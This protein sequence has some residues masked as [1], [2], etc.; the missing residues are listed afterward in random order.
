MPQ[1]RSGSNERGRVERLL[2]ELQKTSY[3]PFPEPR[4]RLEAPTQRGVYIIYSPEGK[5]VHV[6]GTPYARRGLRQRLRNHL[7]GKSSFV[8]K[9][10]KLKRKGSKLR[11]GYGFR[12][13]VVADPRLRALLECLAIGRLCPEHIGQGREE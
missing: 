6:G 5:V 1:N 12:C 4:K 10:P 9:F 11:R 8:K 2:T 13:L 3:R 7:A